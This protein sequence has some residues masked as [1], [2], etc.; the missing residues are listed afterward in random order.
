ML[1]ITATSQQAI[2]DFNDQNGAVKTFNRR[3]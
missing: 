2:G 3:S 1:F